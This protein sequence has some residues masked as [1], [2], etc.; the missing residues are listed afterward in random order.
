MGCRGVIM[1]DTIIDETQKAAARAHELLMC[2]GTFLEG[3]GL[4]S[5]LFDCDKVVLLSAAKRYCNDVE[6]LHRH[7]TINLIDCYKIAGYSA[8]WICKMKPFRV[9]DL[10]VAY[11]GK[12]TILANKM[13]Y[14]NELFSLHLGL[15]RINSHHKQAKSNRRVVLCKKHYDAM[16]YSLKYRQMSGD[17]LS[18]FFEMVGDSLSVAIDDELELLGMYR[19][20]SEADKTRTISVMRGFLDVCHKDTAIKHNSSKRLTL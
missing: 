12:Q 7:H 10:N 20:L 11:M 8:Y 16:A 4:D 1:S 19:Q 6:R 5:S 13:F 3:A 2:F 18:L 14:I 15:S 9:K 17:M